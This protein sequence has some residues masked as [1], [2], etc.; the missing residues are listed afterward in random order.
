MAI[1]QLAPPAADRKTSHGFMPKPPPPRIYIFPRTS[2]KCSNPL[3]G[4]VRTKSLPNATSAEFMSRLG[5]SVRHV[6]HNDVALGLTEQFK[7]HSWFLMSSRCDGGRSYRVALGT[8]DV[9]NQICIS[10]PNTRGMSVY[11]P[12][13]ISGIQSTRS[14]KDVAVPHLPCAVQTAGPSTAA[15]ATTGAPRT[16]TT[17]RGGCGPSAT[18]RA[19]RPSGCAGAPWTVA[20]A[21][22]ARGARA[23]PRAAAA[24]RPSRARCGGGRRTEGRRARGRRWRGRAGPAVRSV[25]CGCCGDVCDGVCSSS[26]AL[27]TAET[28]IE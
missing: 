4:S 7:G 9:L 21:R 3:P 15:A 2:T 8:G 24:R 27:L 1:G 22:G 17:P 10:L 6:R 19:P 28:V 25:V 12:S 16:A 14:W 23:V 5:P 11:D 13:F 20:W 26:C 18:L